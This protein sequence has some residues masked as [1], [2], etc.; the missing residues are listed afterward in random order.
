MTS[1][2]PHPYEEGVAELWINSYAEAFSRIE[3][4]QLAI[5]LGKSNQLIGAIGLSFDS[6]N[7]SAELGYWIGVP[8]WDGP[9]PNETTARFKPAYGPVIVSV[10]KMLLFIYLTS[11][12]NLSL[13]PGRKERRD[14][15]RSGEGEA[16]YT[17]FLVYFLGRRVIFQDERKEDTILKLSAPVAQ[18]AL[19]VSAGG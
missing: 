15:I 2:I 9:S 17:K 8:H 1:N 13:F 10:D 5:T 4:L 6:Q 12:T 18:A 19:I 16:R 3:S 11:F 14:S 7:R